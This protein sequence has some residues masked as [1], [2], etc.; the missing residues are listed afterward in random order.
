MKPLMAYCIVIPPLPRPRYNSVIVSRSSILEWHAQCS[1]VNIGW[2]RCNLGD[3]INIP[4]Y[5][6]AQAKAYKRHIG[7]RFRCHSIAINFCLTRYRT[8]PSRFMVTAVSVAVMVA[9]YRIAK[10]LLS[11]CM[12]RQSCLELTS[13]INH[14]VVFYKS[15]VRVTKHISSVSL[16]FFRII[17]AFASVYNILIIF[18]KCHRSWVALTPIQ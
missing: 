5:N 8:Q 7:V 3:E 2:S 12:R 4:S 17:K 15:W 13:G 6:F 18:D 14:S 11:F 9:W 1:I 16:K 10:K